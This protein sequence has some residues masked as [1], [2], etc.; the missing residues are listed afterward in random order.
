MKTPLLILLS[1]F[2][3]TTVQSSDREQEKRI[4]QKLVKERE[5]KFG[6]Y[7]NA[8]GSRSGFFGNKTKKDL[9]GQLDVMTEIVKTDNRIISTLN[10]FLNYRT[11]QQTTT[12][13]S[14]AELDEKNQRLDELTTSLSK[15]LKAEEASKKALVIRMKWVKVWNY[16]LIGLVIYMGYRLWKEK[17]K[18]VVVNTNS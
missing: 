14:Q 18:V 10:N 13:Y 17:R 3:I 8:A 6:E 12:T 4:L 11:F 5:E 9:Q 1:L 15:K 7:A 2:I 16:L